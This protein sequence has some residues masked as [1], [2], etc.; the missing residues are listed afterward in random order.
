MF[1]DEDGNSI[2]GCELQLSLKAFLPEEKVNQEDEF[3]DV[4]L[5]ITSTELHRIFEDAL[6]PHVCA[7]ID[8]EKAK[9]KSDVEEDLKNFSEVQRDLQE[10]KE[11]APGGSKVVELLAKAQKVLTGAENDIAKRRRR[12]K[13]MRENLERVGEDDD[14]DVQEA[15]QA[16]DTAEKDLAELEQ[17]T[18][19]IR[20]EVEQ[21]MALG[22][23]D[24]AARRHT[25]RSSD[26]NAAGTSVPEPSGAIPF[27]LDR[28][29]TKS[30]GRQVFSRKK[31]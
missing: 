21:N 6:Q 18:A 13:V 24:L 15:R 25:R 2:K 11:S 20:A 5:E 9:V 26:S 1:I 31:T 28:V 7:E 12:M 10:T 29:V 19:E 3:Q 8:D 27:P 23:N 17:K 30:K 4:S 22:R 14:E 16:L